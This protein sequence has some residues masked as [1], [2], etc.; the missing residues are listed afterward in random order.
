MVTK[1]KT[2][3][4]LMD[5]NLLNRRRQECNRELMAVL[6]EQIEMHPSQRFSQILRN[7][8]FVNQVDAADQVVWKDEFNLEPWVLLSRVRE[9]SQRE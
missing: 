5:E 1:T 9:V 2:E 3:E 7:A 4:E 6:G 8:G